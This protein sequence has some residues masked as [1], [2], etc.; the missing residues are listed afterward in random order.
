[1]TLKSTLTIVCIAFQALV[2]TQNIDKIKGNRNVTVKQTYVHDFSSI[3]IGNDFKIELI[4]NSKP[5]VEIETDNNLHEVIEFQVVDGVLTLKTNKRITSKKELKITVNYGDQLS[6]II[7]KNKAEVRS[8]TSMELG[9]TS[10]R[11]ED[12]A[13][14]YLNIKA[15]DFKFVATGKSKTRL[16]INA[17]STV[18]ELSDDCKL[19]AL[20]NSTNSSFDLYQ[21][22]N[23]T[24]EGE[25]QNATLRID[26]SSRFFGSNF[27]VN[28]CQL[29]VEGSS[30]VTLEVKEQFT[31]EASGNSETFL[32]GQPSITVTKLGGTAKLQK[33]ER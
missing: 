17:D 26:N 28:T 11:V 21:R 5:S 33:K 29:V 1:M 7:V 2:Y 18:V 3:T 4:Y 8:L 16:N 27:T 24:I 19:E 30:D 22:A 9:N 32:Y 31:I 15:K 13:R 25:A 6:D 20:I 14:A 12:N 10:L 23:A